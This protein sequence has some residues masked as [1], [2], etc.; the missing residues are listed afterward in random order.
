MIKKVLLV[1]LIVAGALI[2]LGGTIAGISAAAAGGF[3]FLSTAEPYVERIIN[4]E[5]NDVD[6]IVNEVNNKVVVVGSE[7]ATTVSI[8]V[9]ENTYEYYVSSESETDFTINYHYDVPW[10]KRI[11]YF[12]VNPRAMT[13]TIPANYNGSLD[14]NTT[15][16]E[17]DVDNISLVGELD[18]ETVNGLIAANDVTVASDVAVRTTNSKI[19]LTNIT[20]P[21]DISTES[22]N[23]AIILTNLEAANIDSQTTNGMIDADEIRS[24]NKLSLT[25]TNGLVDVNG[26]DID[27]EIRLITVNGEVK[28]NVKGP[29]SDYDVDSRTTNGMN[30]LSGYNSQIPTTADKLLYVRTE[31]GAINIV[32][33]N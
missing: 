11:F 4:V 13:V 26:I 7:A 1:P 5:A 27:K 9:F 3:A 24:T 32:F 6:I 22:D 12:P 21:G 28:G 18:L 33:K 10:P 19:E 2:V 16:G 31:N 8:S 25:T 29:S 30:N 20:A 14:I 23:A 17:L 15:N